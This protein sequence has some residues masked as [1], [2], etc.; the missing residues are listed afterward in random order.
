MS[1]PQFGNLR[2]VC[3]CGHVRG[4]HHERVGKCTPR[5]KTGCSCPAWSP[6]VH[7]WDALPEGIEILK[8]RV[9]DHPAIVA[10]HH[11]EGE[12]VPLVGYPGDMCRICKV[13]QRFD[14]PVKTLAF[15]DP[16]STLF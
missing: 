12:R 9:R 15:V 16:P 7:V 11:P 3:R 1:N 10:C 6:A 2:D 5:S 4:S 8:G 14:R 13:Q